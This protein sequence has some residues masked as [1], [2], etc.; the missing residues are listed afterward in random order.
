MNESQEM[1]SEKGRPEIFRPNVQ[2]WIFL[3]HAL[4]SIPHSDNP[5]GWVPIEAQ[6]LIN[7]ISTKQ[8]ESNHQMDVAT[9]VSEPVV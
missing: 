9:R 6:P 2:W 4:V 3:K 5:G 7:K 1:C 8:S